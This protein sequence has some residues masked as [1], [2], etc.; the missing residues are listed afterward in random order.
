MK[1]RDIIIK[2]KTGLHARPAADFVNKA[3]T[4]KSD[5]KI[6][7]DGVAINGKSIMSLL[8]LAA[9]YNTK[10]TL[11]LEGEDEEIALNVLC[12]LLEKGE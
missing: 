4:F 5:V 7:K 11:V 3:G 2:N 12:K 1:K 9:A 10:L 6:I 8:T